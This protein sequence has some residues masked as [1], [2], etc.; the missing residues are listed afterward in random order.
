MSRPVSCAMTVN[1][2]E[3]IVEGIYH[4][5]DDDRGDGFVARVEHI[6]IAH[7]ATFGDGLSPE[8]EAHAEQLLCEVGNRAVRS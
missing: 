2:R 7:G 4:C 5:D 1:G 8:A 6:R 3:V